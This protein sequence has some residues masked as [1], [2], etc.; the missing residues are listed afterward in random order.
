MFEWIVGIILVILWIRM[1]KIKSLE[2]EILSLQNELS[3]LK[4]SYL[5]LKNELVQANKRTRSDETT[6]KL[7]ETV[8]SFVEPITPQKREDFLSQ[9]TKEAEELV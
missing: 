3:T 6:T 5:Q 1:N 4:E 7:A 9:S 8:Y 2:K